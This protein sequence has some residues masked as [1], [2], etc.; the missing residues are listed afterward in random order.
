MP[1]NRLYRLVKISA[2]LPQPLRQRLW[3]KAFGH[4]VPMVGTAKIQYIHMQP[5]QIIVQLKNHVAVQNHLGQLHAC[6]MALLAETATGF[7]TA[8]NV[9]D[10]AIVLIKSMHIDFKRPTSGRMQAIATLSK[11]QQDLMQNTL[12]GETVVTVHLTDESPHAPI[13]CQMRWAWI[14]KDQLQKKIPD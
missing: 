8:L 5:N 4:I 9:P 10:H 1:H 6:A 14:S 11:A 13:E 12:K 3:N 7:I 2:K